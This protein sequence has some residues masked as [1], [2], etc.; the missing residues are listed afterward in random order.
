ME[1]HSVHCVPLNALYRQLLPCVWRYVCYTVK[2]CISGAL[3]FCY[4]VTYCTVCVPLRCAV[5]K[6]TAPCAPLDF[7]LKTDIPSCEKNYILLL[8]HSATRTITFTRNSRARNFHRRAWEFI[9]SS[10]TSCATKCTQAITGYKLQL[11]IYTFLVTHK[12]S[13][14]YT[15]LC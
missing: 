10:V 9:N 2:Y 4:T 6:R 11:H 3:T 12:K 15:T 5:L 13:C 14:V 8:K 7:I 1:S